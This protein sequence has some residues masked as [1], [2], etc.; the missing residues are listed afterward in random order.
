M[1]QDREGRIHMK[2]YGSM[3][4][5]AC[6]GCCHEAGEPCRKRH[7]HIP[8]G[9]TACMYC[10]RNHYFIIKSNRKRDNYMTM[11]ELKELIKKAGGERR[12]LVPEVVQFT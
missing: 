4:K 7:E 11:D 8:S 6:H 9:E 1:V 10:I 5:E 3:S 2:K 12:R